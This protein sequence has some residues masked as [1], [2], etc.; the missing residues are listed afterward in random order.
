[1]CGDLTKETKCSGWAAPMSEILALL[2]KYM[3]MMFIN[4][5]FKMWKLRAKTH[6]HPL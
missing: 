6:L 1:M 2:G 4:V 5:F 3:N